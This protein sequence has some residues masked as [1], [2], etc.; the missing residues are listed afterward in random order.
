MIPALALTAA[1][2]RTISRAGLIG[3]MIG[4]LANFGLAQKSDQPS[5][6]SLLRL[7]VP[8]RRNQS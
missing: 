8:T 4:Q 5:N 6:H 1:I 7:N 2:L 3:A